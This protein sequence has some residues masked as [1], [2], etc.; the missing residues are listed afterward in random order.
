MYQPWIFGTMVA[1]GGGLVALAVTRQHPVELPSIAPQPAAAVHVVP[2]APPPT[3]VEPASN[4]PLELAPIVIEG[5]AHHR[6][7]AAPSVAP[8]KA[9]ER[10]C[11]DWRALGPAHVVAGSPTGDVSVRTLCP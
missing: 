9:T 3:V 11:S 4:P 1:A 6:A 5:R 10:P 2:P 8:P 7:V